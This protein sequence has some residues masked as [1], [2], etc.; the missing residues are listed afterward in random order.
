MKR[1]RYDFSKYDLVDRPKAAAAFIRQWVALPPVVTEKQ[2]EVTDDQYGKCND[3]RSNAFGGGDV[4]LMAVKAEVW[5]A[6]DHWGESLRPEPDD[7]ATRERRL[8]AWMK[9][10][11]KGPDTR[12]R[13]HLDLDIAKSI[14]R[15]EVWWKREAISEGDGF[16]FG[17]WRFLSWN[18]AEYE[19]LSGRTLAGVKKLIAQS[20]GRELSP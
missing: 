11:P 17:P 3:V 2:I 1:T 20:V 16:I 12:Y 13:L 14:E 7:D 19:C 10:L 5:N 18:D 8:S 6:C 15:Y 4:P 9:D